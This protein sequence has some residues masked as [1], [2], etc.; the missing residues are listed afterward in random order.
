MQV[1][2]RLETISHATELAQREDV[3]LE[4]MAV[5]QPDERTDEPL[6]ATQVE[7]MNHVQHLEASRHAYLPPAIDDV[8]GGPVPTPEARNTN[9]FADN[10]A[11]TLSRG[12]A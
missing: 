2:I 12:T 3:T 4:P 8:T 10:P 7:P 11:G 1:G 9:P 5:H 6:Q